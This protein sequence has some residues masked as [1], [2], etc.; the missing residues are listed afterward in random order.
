MKWRK[1]SDLPDKEGKYYTDIGPCYLWRHE[2]SK[3]LF[4]ANGKRGK[5]T[6]WLDESDGSDEQQSSSL[7]DAL[8]EFAKLNFPLASKTQIAAIVQ[9]YYTWKTKAALNNNNNKKE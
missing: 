2:I 1:A 7:R 3:E 8:E 9:E 4:W 5:V 6:K